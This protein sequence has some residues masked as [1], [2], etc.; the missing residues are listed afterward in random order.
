[1]RKGVVVFLILIFLPVCA[2]FGSLGQAQSYLFDAQNGAALVGGPAGGAQNTNIALVGQ[3]QRSTNPYSFV[4][5]LQSQNAMLVQGAYTV[6][7]DG[8]FGVAQGANVV[9]GQTQ[10]PG[11]GG[12]LGIQNQF[13][14]G[15][16]A[17]DLIK[18]G[19]IGSAMGI[20]G[21]VDLQVQ[22]IV[23]PHGASTNVQYLGLAQAD[24]VGGGP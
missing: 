18:N 8:L 23:S 17:Q 5:A 22:L 15:A 19:G 20:Q 3:N 1:M 4:T 6:G 7:M 13:L 12:S 11:V 14:E 10:V 2:S 24:S 21:L 9:G 16:F